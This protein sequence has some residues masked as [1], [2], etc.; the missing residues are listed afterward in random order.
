M[1]L[2]M[3]GNVSQGLSHA[4]LESLRRCLATSRIA[5]T[6]PR[7]P[8][9]EECL[10]HYDHNQFYPVHVGQYLD[11]SYKVTGKLG[12]SADSTV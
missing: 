7:Q 5:S 1:I 11:S 9:E 8:F 12:Y 4:R 2:T 10:P 6:D 3:F